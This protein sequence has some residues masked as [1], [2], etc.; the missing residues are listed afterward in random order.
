MIPNPIQKVPFDALFTPGPIPA[1]G[2][3]GRVFY[4]GAEFS[5][6]C[7]VAILCEPQN[8]VRL[9]SALDEL[10]AR[11]IA[12]PPFEADYLLRGHAVHFRSHVPD[13]ENV[14]LEESARSAALVSP[15][16]APDVE[17]IRLDAMARM[18]GVAS[19]DELWSRRAT[20]ENE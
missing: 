14:R 15:C 20:L 6:D 12:V 17:N 13:V 2:R 1:D 11:T 18:R 8:L 7:D 19:F 16:H 10:A 5:R 4:G 9:Q 3:P